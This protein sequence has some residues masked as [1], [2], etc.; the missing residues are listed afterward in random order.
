MPVSATNAAV[1]GLPAVDV[2]RNRYESVHTSLSLTWYS[3]SVS[4]ASSVNL[5]SSSWPTTD[6]VGITVAGTSVQS[7]DPNGLDRARPFS[8]PPRHRTVIVVALLS[9]HASRICSTSGGGGAS[10]GGGWA[11]T[12]DIATPSAKPTTATLTV[13]VGLGRITMV[14]L[15][16]QRSEASGIAL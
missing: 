4:G 8:L 11:C 13:S 7:S 6:S 14:P 10:A 9:T 1:T 15:A 12:V 3:W 5:T 2:V 16:R